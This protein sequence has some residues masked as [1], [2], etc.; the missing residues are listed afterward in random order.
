MIGQIYPKHLQELIDELGLLPG[1]G[2]KSAQRIAFYLLQVSPDRLLR[3]SSVIASLQDSTRLCSRCFNISEGELCHICASSSRDSST[4]CVVEDPRDVIA[5]ERSNAFRGKY[6]V[7]H[8]A[9]S[10]IDGIGPEKLKIGELMSRIESEGIKEVIVCTNP[11]VEGDATAAWIARYLKDR[12]VQVSR[13]A[14]GLPVGGDL[15][16]ADEVTLSRAL[17]GRHA[18]DD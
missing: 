8:G 6:H 16:Y 15:E 10:P 7:L 11:T 17:S 14:S 4:I 9:I 3:L 5:L 13:I 18:I 12:G 2:P 1:I